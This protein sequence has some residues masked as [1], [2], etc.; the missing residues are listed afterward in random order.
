MKAFDDLKALVAACETDVLKTDAGNNA[1]AVRVRGKMQ[2][3]K[4][5]VQEVREEAL[6]LKK[7]K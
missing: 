5:K 6:A 1:A 7:K 4:A 2:E 3:I